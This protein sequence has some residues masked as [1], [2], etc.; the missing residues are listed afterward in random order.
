VYVQL[1]G[2]NSLL[3]FDGRSAV[4]VTTPTIATSWIGP[5]TY[6]LGSGVRVIDLL[7]LADPLTAHLRL[8]KRGEIAGHEKPLPTPWI[9]AELVRSG[10][11]TDQLDSLA[12]QRPQD[13]TPLISEATGRQLTIESAWA[14]AALQC[15]AIKDL[16]D[17][18]TTPLTVG[19]FLS[20][21][22]H[23]VS[24]TRLRIPPNPETAYHLFCGPGTPSQVR[25][26]I[27]DGSK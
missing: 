3:R 6:E 20:N 15:P 27:H 21:I 8:A 23:A 10:S 1:A 9:S 17:A 24:L 19:T 11:P 2:P 18:P 4:H 13:F 16:R 22:Y 14:R 7:G 26:V 12:Q 25:R 5:E